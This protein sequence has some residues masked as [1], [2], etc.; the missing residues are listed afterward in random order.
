MPCSRGSQP[1]AFDHRGH[2]GRV[3]LHCW[4]GCHT[5]DVL[6]ALGLDW[7]A[8]FAGQPPSSAETAKAR[9]EH[10]RAEAERQAKRD[11]ELGKMDRVMRLR[12]VVDS[13][14]AKL[15]LM[16]DGATG[17]DAMGR[18]F[19]GAC[20]LLHEAETAQMESPAAHGAGKDFT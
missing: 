7:R 3:L 18:L 11:S 15:A 4:A 9:R 1:F 5:R 10:E 17:A 8:L 20:D 19:H 2:D 6:K 16:P 13:L 12:R 14:G